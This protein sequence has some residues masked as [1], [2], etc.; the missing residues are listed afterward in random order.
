MKIYK[1]TTVY[2]EALNRIRRVFDEFDTVVVS[3]SGGKDSTVVYHLALQVA[4]EKN[5]LPLPVMFLDQ[6]FEWSST[7]EQIRSMMSNPDVK[8]YWLQLPFVMNNS[9]AVG[10]KDTTWIKL[11]ERGK[12]DDYYV[13]PKDPLAIHDVDVPDLI[14]DDTRFHDMFGV[15]ARYFFGKNTAFIAGMRAEEN[16]TRAMATTSTAKYKDITWANGLD[17]KSNIFTFYPIYDWTV[18]DVWKAICDGG[19]RYSSKYNQLYQTGCSITNMRVSALIH[20]TA[21]GSLFELQE[22]EPELY[23]RVIRRIEGSDTIGKMGRDDFMPKEL[24]F[25]F[26]DWE[27]YANYL[28]DNLVTDEYFMKGWEQAKKRIKPFVDNFPELRRELWYEMAKS[29]VGNDGDFTRIGNNLSRPQ[30]VPYKKK[31]KKLKQKGTL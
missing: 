5:R 24:P 27:E 23:E 6:E 13:Q 3:C 22:A 18:G 15:C 26:D 30:M 8:P 1:D 16:P 28:Y 7:R 19:W 12:D 9:A 10:N 29:V 11:W 4:K 2:E 17:R 31:L 21:V 20:E 25:M 14:T